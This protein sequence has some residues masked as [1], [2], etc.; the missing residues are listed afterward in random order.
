MERPL[1]AAEVPRPTSLSQGLARL[2]QAYPHYLSLHPRLRAVKSEGLWP[3]GRE[4]RLRSQG[5]VLGHKEG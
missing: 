1:E 3:R 5:G 4:L 2:G